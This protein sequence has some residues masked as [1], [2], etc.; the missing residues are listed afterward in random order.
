MTPE[1][2][3]PTAAHHTDPDMADAIL[4]AMLLNPHHADAIAALSDEELD[5]IMADVPDA[6]EQPDAAE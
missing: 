2:K 5:S 3:Q 1:P 6:D 4:E